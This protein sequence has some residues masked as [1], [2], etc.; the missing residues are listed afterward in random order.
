MRRIQSLNNSMK[1]TNKITQ[2]VKQEINSESDLY[3]YSDFILY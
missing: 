1:P 3:K 2:I